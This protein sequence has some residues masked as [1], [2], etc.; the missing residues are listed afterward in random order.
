MAALALSLASA[1]GAASTAY[2]GGV[3]TEGGALQPIN[4]ADNSLGTV[5]HLS[6]PSGEEFASP[7]AVV[8]SPDQK[9]AYAV[10]QNLTNSNVYVTAVD[11]LTN[12]AAAP[13]EIAD[14]GEPK[15]AAITSD[16][17]TM[18]IAVGGK[19]VFPLNLETGVAGAAIA[20]PGETVNGATGGL[21]FSP[22]GSKLYVASF[23]NLFVI[24]TATGTAEAEPTSPIASPLLG[25]AHHIATSPDG[26][27]VWV[28]SES[29]YLVPVETATSTA[30]AR[31]NTPSSAANLTFTKDGSTIWALA[32][33]STPKL[34]SVDPVARTLGTEIAFAGSGMQVELFGT[35]LAV[36]SNAKTAYVSSARKFAAVNLQAGTVGTP[37]T[38]PI[39]STSMAVASIAN[40]AGASTPTI[41][42][43]VPTQSGVVGDPTNPTITLK[44]AQLDENGEQV[45]P[46]D[47]HVSVTTQNEGPS[48]SAPSHLPTANVTFTG[49]GGERE[50]HF[51]PVSPGVS[52]VTFTV[53][54]EGGKTASVDFYYGI[55]METTPTS[56]VLEGGSDQSTAIDVGEGDLLV[57]DDE[58][59]FIRLY[60]TE[61]SGAPLREYNI[62]YTNTQE[63]D[64]E[65][66]ARAGNTIYWLGS[67]GNTQAGNADVGR[68]HVI[69]TEVTGSGDKTQ[70]TPVGDYDGLLRDM[71]AWDK[72]RKEGGE[73]LGIY[74]GQ[75]GPT[76]QSESSANIEGAEFAPNSS[77]ELYLGLRTPTVLVGNGRDALIVPVTN[78]NKVVEGTEAHA[79]FAEPILLDLDGLGIREIRKNAAGQYLIIGGEGSSEEA[80]FSWTGER[81]DQPV[82]L[83]TPL[84]P[85]EEEWDD[86]RGVWEG[87][88]QMPANLTSGS[89]VRLIMDQGET[90]PYMPDNHTKGKQITDMRWRKSRTDLFTL[91]GNVGS[92]VSAPAPTFPAQAANTI[93]SGQW[94]TVT[95]TG[96]QNLVVSGVRTAD[97][98]G[99][100]AGDFL[101]TQNECLGKTVRIG[102]T[103][104][105]QVRFAPARESTTSHAQLVL[106][107]NVDGTASVA[108]TGT[109]TTL[110]VGPTGPQGNTGPTG[111]TGAQGATGATGAT[112]STGAQGAAGPQGAKGD[113]GAKG[114]KG[115]KGEAGAKGDKGA[116]GRDGTVSFTA[117]RASANARRGHKL[118]LSFQLH[119]GT[120]AALSKA[121]ATADLPKGLKASGDR[122]VSVTGVKA[123][124]TKTVVLHLTVGKAKAGTYKVPVELSIGG[125]TVTS[126][127]TVRVGS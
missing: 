30:A 44:V 77:S 86:D 109:S 58:L 84:P 125:H 40:P 81:G 49:T 123:G 68:Q 65:S 12:V 60:S 46:E 4:L 116:P 103:C 67:H 32:S 93:G 39:Y 88:G 35:G 42:T 70:L 121:T 9:T 78:I 73:G 10:G 16:G 31:V 52:K 90:R 1:A 102:A 45:A 82:R 120:A 38:L 18:Y 6:G 119:N 95:N 34:V 51:D 72:A 92:A 85:S 66:S 83:T 53:T 69:A 108:L 105:V 74:M 94:V 97:S 14:R 36:S 76:V 63:V 114:D 57:A 91:T 124:A 99:A 47:L 61:R 41:T 20:L 37:V 64:F 7:N 96:A 55:S 104:K 101:V 27:V 8:V 23:S 56:R 75:L 13:I 54:G 111:S 87:I 115:D 107:G 28:A 122:S 26:S 29:P 110:P 126:T 48:A 62:G 43:D 5:I 11:T 106:E 71:L 79:K 127:V 113:T 24:D 2:L 50:V 3:S 25:G 33:G 100:S 22:D 17:K 98:D 112:G 21:S 15:G 117:D 118:E 59:S 19:G 89:Q 80:L